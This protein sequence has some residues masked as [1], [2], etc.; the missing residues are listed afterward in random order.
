MQLNLIRQIHTLCY[1]ITELV[2]LSNQIQLRER[3]SYSYCG[4]SWC[5]ANKSL[6]K[7]NFPSGWK[8]YKTI[9]SYVSVRS[10]RYEARGKF[11][12]QERCARVLASCFFLCFI[13]RWT[14][15][16]RMNQLFYNIFNSMEFFFPRGICLLTSWVCT[17]EVWNT[18]AQLNL[19]RQYIKV[20]TATRWTI[21]HSLTLLWF[22][23]LM[24]VT[25]EVTIHRP[26]VSTLLSSAFIRGGHL[27][28]HLVAVWTL[29]YFKHK[30]LLASRS[31]M[32]FLIFF[33]F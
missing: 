33:I 29:I 1:I 19:I 22:A 2:N 13:S 12:E 16:W 28:V 20:H 23:D 30:C 27:I 32:Y 11:G 25:E 4:R 5:S 24:N 3:A 6:E 31:T 8:C 26:N 14:H 9:G 21:R 17:I 15:S 7:K 18:L 10:S